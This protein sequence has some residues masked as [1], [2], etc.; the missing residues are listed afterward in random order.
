MPLLAETN[1][2]ATA[3]G[4]GITADPLYRDEVRRSCRSRP[5][6]TS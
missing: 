3:I 1:L 6:S 5:A 2:G 4:T